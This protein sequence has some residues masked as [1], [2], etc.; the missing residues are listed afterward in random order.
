MYPGKKL[1]D[2]YSNEIIKIGD[3]STIVRC[4]CL[5]QILSDKIC[6]IVEDYEVVKKYY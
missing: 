1:S 6:A 3:S 2:L 5:N 4:R